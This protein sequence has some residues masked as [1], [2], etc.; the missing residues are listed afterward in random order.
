[1]IR[2]HFTPP[3]GDPAWNDWVRDGQEAAARMLADQTGKHTIDE[4]LYKR[5][6]DR[7]LGATHRKCAYCELS[8][9]VGQRKG[10]VEHYR[11]KGRARGLDGKIVKVQRDGVTID[12]PGY[13]WL[14][15]DH[16]NLLPACLACNRRAGDAASGTNTGKSDIFPT[17]NDR[18]ATCPGDVPVEQ[19]AL[20]NPWLDDPAEHLCFDPDTG[21][22]IGITERGRVTECV[23]GLNRDGLPE[24]RRK[25]GRDVRRVLR[26]GISDVVHDGADPDDFDQL[27]SVREGSAEY[28]AICRVEY[29]RG[30][31]KIRDFLATLDYGPQRATH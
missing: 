7:F 18:W 25:A 20:L 11:P 30:L 16:L 5:Q 31:Q 22:V 17:L 24:A 21:L 4:A 13:Y 10:D 14:A 1:M 8:L 2:L 6:R 3:V 23:L 19:P 12:H 27:Q 26:V 29:D 28:A 9:P 15:Y